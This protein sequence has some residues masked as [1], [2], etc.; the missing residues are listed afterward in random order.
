MTD[1]IFRHNLYR[2]LCFSIIR[3]C[4]EMRE[5]QRKDNEDEGV[6]SDVLTRQI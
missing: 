2:G 6:R 4:K 3:V 5:K 1:E